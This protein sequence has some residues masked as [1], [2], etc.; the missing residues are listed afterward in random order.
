MFP[1]NAAFYIPMFYY[2]PQTYIIPNPQFLY[3]DMNIFTKTETSFDSL[4]SLTIS[5][6]IERKDDRENDNSEL[7]VPVKNQDKCIDFMKKKIIRKKF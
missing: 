7:Y 2:A 6:Q 1:I 5:T 4:T 3:S